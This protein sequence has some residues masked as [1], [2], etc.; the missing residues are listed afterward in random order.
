MRWARILPVRSKIPTVRFPGPQALWRPRGAAPK[1][2]VQTEIME[3]AT[4]NP[5]WVLKSEMKSRTILTKWLSH[6]NR[7]SGQVTD[8]SYE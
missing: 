5:L 4:V 6:P 3:T 2:S 7:A 8:E 1:W